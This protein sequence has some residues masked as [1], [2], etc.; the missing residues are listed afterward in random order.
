MH[1]GV[2]NC[3]SVKWYLS[4]SVLVTPINVQTQYRGGQLYSLTIVIA[5][6]VG[7][8]MIMLAI[9]GKDT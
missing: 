7:L 2:S 9:N 3:I 6:C 8:V 5:I 4:V 1:I